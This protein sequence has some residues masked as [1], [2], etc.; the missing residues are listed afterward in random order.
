[1][2]DAVSISSFV[3]RFI[4]P[5]VGPQ[6]DVEQRFYRGTIL[7]IQTNQEIGFTEWAEALSFMQQFVSLDK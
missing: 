7:H 4:H 6:V 3:I 1:M 5:Q 2:D